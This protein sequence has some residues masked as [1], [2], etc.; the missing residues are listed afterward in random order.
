MIKCG[1]I[2][3][4]FQQV[5]KCVLKVTVNENDDFLIGGAHDLDQGWIKDVRK[6]GAKVV[7]RL[8]FDR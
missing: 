4:F 5:E 3:N 1:K 8:L 7:P 6:H 2:Y